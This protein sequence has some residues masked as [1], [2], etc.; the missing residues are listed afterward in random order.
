MVRATDLAQRVL[1]PTLTPGDWVV[2]ATMG[3]GHDTVWLANCVGSTGRVFGFDVQSAALA[4]TSKRVRGLPQVTLFP[5]GHEHL[6]DHLPQAAKHH[7]AA[8]MFNLGYLPGAPKAIA[9][10]AAT[11]LAGLGQALDFLRVGGLVSLVLY[12]GHP[13][14]AHEADA[15]RAYIQTLPTVFAATQCVRINALGAPPELCLVERVR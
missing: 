1:R 9:T 3:N 5:H 4:A 6:A 8:V 15:V 7:L 13:G 12:P 2:D 10:D 11:T 14:G